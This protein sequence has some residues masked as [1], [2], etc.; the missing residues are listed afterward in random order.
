MINMFVHMSATEEGG[1]DRQMVTFVA[2]REAGGIV[3]FVGV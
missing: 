1:R 2:A 3:H